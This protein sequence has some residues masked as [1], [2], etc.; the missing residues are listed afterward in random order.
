MFLF[1]KV[2]E[3]YFFFFGIFFISMFGTYFY[4]CRQFNLLLVYVYYQITISQPLTF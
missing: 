2:I 4:S 3:N 1:F